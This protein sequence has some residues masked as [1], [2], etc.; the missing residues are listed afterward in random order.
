MTRSQKL[1]TAYAD[2]VLTREVKVSSRAAYGRR[3][4]LLYKLGD[5]CK[6]M[7]TVEGSESWVAWLRAN[8]TGA[9]VKQTLA[10]ARGF[11][12]YCLE[13]GVVKGK[14]PFYPVDNQLAM[15]SPPPQLTFCLHNDNCGDSHCLN[16]DKTPDVWTPA[17]IEN[18]IAQAPNEAT[19]DFWR[20]CAYEGM[21]HQEAADIILGTQNTPVGANHIRPAQPI[22]PITPK[23]YD[24]PLSKHPSQRCRDLVRVAPGGSFTKFRVSF[25]WNLLH[26]AAEGARQALP[27]QEVARRMGLKSIKSLEGLL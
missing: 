5:W 21:R 15:S 25:A 8:Y 1:L 7:V 14:D 4:A 22:T 19:R 18:I 10:L 17:E 26:P 12:T 2:T 27:V 16:L 13:L 6:G 11:W 20:L 24:P 3:L 23:T 9:T